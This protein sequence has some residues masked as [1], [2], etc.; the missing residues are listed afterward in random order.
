MRTVA[1][2]V[3]GAGERRARRDATN[4]APRALACCGSATWRIVRSS[5]SACIWHHTSRQR[6]A[7]DEVEVV[8][9]SLDELL[10]GVEQ[11][12]RVVRHAL[13]HRRTRSARVVD[14]E[15]LFQPPRIVW[16]S[17]GVRSPLSQGGEH[18]PC[19]TRPA[20]LR[21]PASFS[22]SKSRGHADLCPRSHSSAAP[23]TSCSLAR[24]YRPG[25]R[26]RQRGLVVQ[27]VGLL[28]RHVAR[29]PRRRADVE[30]ALEVAD[31]ARAHHRR[32]HVAGGG[33]DLGARGAGPTRSASAGVTSP[34]TVADGTSSG[35]FARSTPYR[36]SSSVVV[37]DV[38]RGRGCR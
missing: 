31:G 19:P 28:P 29:Q 13:E 11:P 6:A 38:G 8:H 10:D 9:L 21:R 7:A 17:T 33:D 30:V 26:R 25:M 36:A 2:E 34:T 5:T 4:A 37:V 12:A 1:V 23:A 3:V 35:S 32:V 18:A 14:S 16:S 20:R 27:E 15:R 24:K 22:S